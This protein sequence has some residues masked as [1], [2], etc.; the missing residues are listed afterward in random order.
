MVQICRFI[1]PLSLTTLGTLSFNVSGIFLYFLVSCALTS[2]GWEI[3]PLPQRG[4]IEGFKIFG[5]VA[6]KPEASPGDT[7][8]I[9]PVVTDIDGEGRALSFQAE[10]CEGLKDE[11][12]NFSCDGRGFHSTVSQNAISTLEAPEYTGAGDEFTFTVPAD[13]LSTAE[14][15]TAGKILT[16]FYKLKSADGTETRAMKRVVVSL[17]PAKHRNPVLR[18]IESDI[19]IQATSVT[20]NSAKVRPLLELTGLSQ[21]EREEVRVVWYSSQGEFWWRET[22]SEG[23]NFFNPVGKE[24][25]LVKRPPLI[26]L[27]TRDSKGGSAFYKKNL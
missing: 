22:K 27:I 18:G 19:E 7:V 6:D 25:E 11:R 14:E 24:K 16:V 2:C 10:I 8:T 1:S 26:L 15:K 20:A 23:V 21:M 4:K 12:A 5:L 17:K 9:T 13:F 3:D